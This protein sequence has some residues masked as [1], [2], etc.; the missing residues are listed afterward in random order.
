MS[1]NKDEMV[2]GL[3]TKEPPLKHNEKA[4]KEELKTINVYG[5]P[6]AWVDILKKKGYSFASFTRLAIEEKMKREGLLK[7]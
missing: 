3:G 6:A 4:F 5:I 2:K 7:D 1:V